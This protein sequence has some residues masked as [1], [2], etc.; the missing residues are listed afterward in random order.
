MMAVWS[1]DRWTFGRPAP[2]KAQ[3]PLTVRG[4][5][6]ESNDVS[7]AVGLRDP[8]DSTSWVA[9]GPASWHALSDLLRLATVEPC[10]QA[11]LSSPLGART[12]GV[13]VRAAAGDHQARVALSGACRKGCW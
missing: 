6:D 11:S 13:A 12:R 10:D 1:E 8:C 9:V 7:V 3:P 2:G 5:S 4:R